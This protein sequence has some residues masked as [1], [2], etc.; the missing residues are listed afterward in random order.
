MGDA[1]LSSGRNTT[2]FLDLTAYA[3][4]ENKLSGSLVAGK[5]EFETA[6]PN[7]RKITVKGTFS[8]KAK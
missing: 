2:G 8:F 5:F 3:D 1:V 4:D 6:D 7:G